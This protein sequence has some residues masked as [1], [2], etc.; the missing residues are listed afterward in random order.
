MKNFQIWLNEQTRPR[1]LLLIDDSVEDCVLI[2]KY[3][4]RFHCEWS[5]ANSMDTAA[6]SLEVEKSRGG[7]SLIFLDLN[8]GAPENGIRMFR[9][10]KENWPK[11]PVVVLSGHLSTD[12][13]NQ[14]TSIG[15]AIFAQ[16]PKCFTDAYFDELFHI[17]NIPLRPVI[18]PASSETAPAI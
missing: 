13:I 10:I 2:Q 7:F 9:A 6:F 15:F 17:M 1:R 12:S 11:I 5:V 18:L 3:T 8:L 4:L 16:K 14:I